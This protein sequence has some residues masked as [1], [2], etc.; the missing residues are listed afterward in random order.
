[1]NKEH[2]IHIVIGQ[3]R[4]SSVP[5]VLLCSSHPYPS[6]PHTVISESGRRDHST[7]INKKG[8]TEEVE[9]ELTLRHWVGFQGEEMGLGKRSS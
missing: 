1:M 7:Q 6:V 8:W 2:S 3:D 4:S 5:A 9:V